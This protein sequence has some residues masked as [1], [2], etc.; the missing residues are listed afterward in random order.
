MHSS[1]LSQHD[2]EIQ[3][4]V[5]EFYDSVGWKKV[6]SELYQNARYED[7]RPVSRRYIQRCHHR[8]KQSLPETGRYLLDAGSGPIQYPEYLEYSQGFT[9]RVCLDLSL[10]ALREAQKRLG[11][12]GLYIV[13][14]ISSLPFKADTFDGIVSL[15]T[16]HHLAARRHRTAF[17]ELFKVLKSGGKAVVVTSWGHRS[18]LMRFF[19]LPIS[20]AFKLIRLYRRIVGMQPALPAQVEGASGDTVEL[21]TAP[22]TFTEKH[23]FQWVNQE[24][25]D[26]PH[27]DVLVWRSVNSS[28]LRAF[29][30]DRLLG[31]LWLRVIFEIEE[32]FPRLLGRLGQYPMILFRKPHRGS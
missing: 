18:A 7:L 16:I 26:F 15:H 25:S 32:L 17:L 3:S 28:F 6:S 31:R 20:A 11:K 23:D 22:G 19:K 27:L 10:R 12:H 14:D 4:Q 29:I 30:H 2:S 5:R 13:G 24:L 21:L 8:V 9:F 1:T